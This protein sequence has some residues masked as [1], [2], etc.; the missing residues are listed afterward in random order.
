MPHRRPILIDQW[1]AYDYKPAF[2]E[3]LVGQAPTW[4]DQENRR[5][6][7]AYILLAAYLENAAREYLPNEKDQDDRR[8]YGDPSLIVQTLVDAVLGDEARVQVEGAR[9]TTEQ[10]DY[11]DTLQDFLEEWVEGA[12]TQSAVI[13]CE[14]NAVTFGDGVYVLGWDARRR[15]VT[16]DCFD[17]GFYFPV[18]EPGKFDREFPTRVH[19]AW[20]FEDNLTDPIRPQQFIRRITY[21]LVDV[22]ELNSDTHDTSPRNYPWRSEPSNFACLKTDAT[23]AWEDLGSRTFLDLDSRG[24][25]FEV[26]ADGEPVNR[27]DIGVDFVPVVHVPNTVNHGEHFG[28]SSLQ[29]VLQ[30]LDDVQSIDTDL[31]KTSRTTGSPPLGSKSV[32]EANEKG[33]VTTYGPGQIIQGEVTVIDT[34]RNLDALLKYLDF[35]LKRLATN[36]RIPDAVL[37]KLRPSEVPSGVALALSFGPLRALVRRLRLA[38]MEKY[39][40]LFNFVLRFSMLDQRNTELRPA[41]DRIENMPQAQF[42]FGQF[43]PSDTTTVITDILNLLREHIISRGTAIR[44]LIEDAGMSIRD[45]SDEVTQIEREDFEG[46]RV[47][48]EALDSPEA[49]A[50]Y[51][52]R[53]IP[54]ISEGRRSTVEAEAAARPAP[55]GGQPPS[56][57]GGVPQNEGQN[58]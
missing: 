51:V 7:Q 8:E 28:R 10:D 47:L 45:A 14:E 23:W 43:L 25:R 55:F 30:I 57:N 5:R 53:E 15:R 44:L 46:A 26:N 33:E 54:T 40:V 27:L 1:S 56:N 39:P 9:R 22:R 17:P 4:V 32:V 6:L 19:L 18:L 11:A 52:G 34:S 31:F 24:A 41:R 48:G 36:S 3:G 50:E 38:R 16:L 35:T 13:H 37:G 2:S 20:E 49:A 58:Q 29:K 21:E 42:T 12:Q